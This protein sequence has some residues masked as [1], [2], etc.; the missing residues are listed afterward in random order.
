MS[1]SSL[2]FVVVL[3]PPSRASSRLGGVV[4][5][6][7]TLAEADAFLHTDLP[8]VLVIDSAVWWHLS[9][10]ERARQRGSAI[11]AVGAFPS[12]TLADEWVKDG[13]DP[14]LPARLELAVAACTDALTGS[15][16]R[17]RGGSLTRKE[18]ESNDRLNAA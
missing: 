7:A 10:A 4:C 15:A 11:V 3:G 1:Q 8:D 2:K 18:V 14:D 13:A 5:H 12:G 17:P 16:A 6:C 9:V